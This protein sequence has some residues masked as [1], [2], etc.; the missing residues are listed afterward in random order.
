MITTREAL[1]CET[2][3][4]YQHNMECIGNIMENNCMLVLGWKGLKSS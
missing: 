1:D 2:N 3:S 4:P